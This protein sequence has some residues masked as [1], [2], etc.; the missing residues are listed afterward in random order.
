[1]AITAAGTAASSSGAL[2]MVAFGIG[3]M[4]ALFLVGGAAQWFSR[5]RIWMLKG[6]GLIV[7]LMGCYNL[8]RHLTMAGSVCH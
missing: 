4:P 8:F 5:K 6:A 7:A 1:M 2:T 3:T